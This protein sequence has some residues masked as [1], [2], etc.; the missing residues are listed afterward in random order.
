MAADADARRFSKLQ[1]RLRAFEGVGG[2]RLR[3]VVSLNSIN[4]DRGLLA[5]H[6]A[7]LSAYEERALYLLFA[8]RRRHVRLV[9]VTAEPLAE[10]I[11]DYYLS[12]L[13]NPAEARS[14]LVLLA[15]DDPSPRPLSVKVLE[16]PQLLD[17]LRELVDGDPDAFIMPFNVRPEERE[18]AVLL[19][20]PIYGVDDRFAQYGTKS[21]GRRLF[22]ASGV[23]HPR[24]AEGVHTREDLLEAI[25]ALRRDDPRLEAVVIKQ[26]DNVFGEGNTVLGLLDLPAAGSTMERAAL[27]V[28]LRSLPGDYLDTLARDGGVVEEMISGAE[29][30]SPS[31]QL[32][33]LPGGNPLI[34]STHDQVLG[35]EIGQ[36]FVGCRFP[37]SPEYASV[38]MAEAGKVGRA[39]A[40]LGVVGRFGV[41]FVVTRHPDGT[42]R[43]YAVEINLREGGTSHPWGTLWLLSGG[44]FDPGSGA[45]VTARGPKSYFATDHLEDPSYRAIPLGALLD[46]TRQAGLDYD[47][48]RADGVVLH[49]LRSL[50]REGRVSAVAI[51]SGPE[52]ANELYLSLTSLLDELAPSG[53]SPRATA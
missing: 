47:P 29:L 7:G 16:R 38:I 26:D 32:R 11:V 40:D 2:D 33:V 45:Y 28:R 30:A 27:D 49:M 21:G 19:D 50:G 34:L 13:P 46:A 17:R 1:A 10:E 39:L 20:I 6:A 53:R 52:Q 36:T 3:T 31:V 22:A 44:R 41:D 37:A 25:I 8:L 35:G 14:R 51:G 15:C 12:F 43:A 23:Q 5:R 9:M 42:P 24:G 48:L 4:L 18:I